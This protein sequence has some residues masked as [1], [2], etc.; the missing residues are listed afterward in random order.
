[1]GVRGVG[2]VVVMVHGVPGEARWGLRRVVKIRSASP[3]A[4]TVPSSNRAVIL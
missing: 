2:V 4:G 1:M 3:A